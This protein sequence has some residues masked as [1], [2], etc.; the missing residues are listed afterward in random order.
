MTPLIQQNTCWASADH[1]QQLQT[2]GW[3][4]WGAQ[5]RGGVCNLSNCGSVKTTCSYLWKVEL[6]VNICNIWCLESRIPLLFFV[7]FQDST[8]RFTLCWILFFKINVWV[9]TCIKVGSK[10]WTNS[11]RSFS[12]MWFRYLGEDASW[13]PPVGGLPGRP[14]TRWRDYRSGLG[15]LQDPPGGAG[16]GCWG[17]RS[18]EYSLSLQPPR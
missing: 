13:S 9:Y 10:R 16:K 1:S 3:T 18:L 17:I 14:R 11:W 4:A 8:Y 5:R 2:C 7:G 15:T 6:W 12:F